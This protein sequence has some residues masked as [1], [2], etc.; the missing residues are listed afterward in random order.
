MA[1]SYLIKIDSDINQEKDEIFKYILNNIDINKVDEIKCIS[2]QEIGMICQ[3]KLKQLGKTFKQKEECEDI[4]QVCDNNF[5]LREVI[6]SFNEC[7]HK[8]HKKCMSKHFKTC[9]TNI[10]PCCKDKYLV[11]V[12]NLI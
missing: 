1:N 7:E 8:F 12:F 11:N 3:N 9:K 10:C 6:F 5:N 2:S 4:C